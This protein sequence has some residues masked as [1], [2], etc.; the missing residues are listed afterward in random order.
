[1]VARDAVYIIENISNQIS[2]FI[3]PYNEYLSELIDNQKVR[4]RAF[5]PMLQGWIIGSAL[6]NFMNRDFVTTDDG[7]IY[8]IANEQD[9]EYAIKYAEGNLSRAYYRMNEHRQIIF[10]LIKELQESKLA[11]KLPD[12]VSDIN[13][14]WVY[15]AQVTNKGVH[16]KDIIETIMNQGLIERNSS[17]I[18]DQLRG[19]VEDGV[20]KIRK[21]ITNSHE[22]RELGIRPGNYY[23]ITEEPDRFIKNV[24]WD[25]IQHEIDQWY[26]ENI[27][28]TTAEIT[29]IDPMTLKTQ[30]EENKEDFDYLWFLSGNVILR[31]FEEIPSN[32]TTS[33]T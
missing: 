7:K 17:W 22:D 27:E 10:D 15:G 20:L 16:S 8:L 25:R 33:P 30:L 29:Q 18:Y 13:Q 6:L 5:N 1:M 23:W 9:L 24:D 14:D 28:Q 4:A 32:W 11:V 3:I 26:L 31:I 2:D 12:R 21:I 19:M